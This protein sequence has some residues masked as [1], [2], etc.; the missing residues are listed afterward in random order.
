MAEFIHSRARG[1]MKSHMSS[2]FAFVRFASLVGL[3]AAAAA[4]CGSDDDS[5]CSSTAAAIC[6]RAC[7][8]GGSN[9]CAIGDASGAITFDSKQDCLSFYALACS[10]PEPDI[11][12]GACES[13][14]D[15][16]QC[17]MTTSG[18]V[19]NPPAACNPPE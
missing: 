7:E 8:C 17:T 6:E 5:D 10:Q 14:V 19:F 13:A 18:Q 2:W 11:D 9:A 15:S 3:L 12:Y 16:A 1:I 4:G